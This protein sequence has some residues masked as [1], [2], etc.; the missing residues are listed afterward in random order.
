VDGAAVEGDAIDP[1]VR[2]SRD[3]RGA[4]TVAGTAAAGPGATGAG[5]SPPQAESA[6][7]RPSRQGF[8]ADRWFRIVFGGDF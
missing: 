8:V 2:A 7:E 3:R 6:K 5:A 4:I 1:R